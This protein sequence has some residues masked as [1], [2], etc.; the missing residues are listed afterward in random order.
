[1]AIYGAG[2]TWS[3]GEEMKNDFFTNENFVLGWDKESARDLYEAI[4]SLKVGDIIYL[5]SSQPG[6]RTLRIKGIG[7]VSKS[8][9]QCILDKEYSE[10]EIKNWE[11]LS[12]NVKWIF[13][14]EFFIEIPEDEGRLTNVRAA[15]FYEEFFPLIQ[16][17]I[18]DKIFVDIR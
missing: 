13:K 10:D 14:N 7:I 9:I 8:V 17:A 11:S 1:M 5:K 12:I 4:S 15:S 16:Y 3:G 2:S 6:S 18:I